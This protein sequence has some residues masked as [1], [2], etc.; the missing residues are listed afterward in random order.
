M[1]RAGR[2]LPPELTATL[3]EMTPQE[4]AYL[5]RALKDPHTAQ[6]ELIEADFER[7]PVSI[8]EF[9]SDP[10]LLGNTGRIENWETDEDESAGIYSFWRHELSDL[11][12]LNNAY[13]QW[14][15]QAGIGSGKSFVSIV[16]ILYKLYVLLCMR[17]PQEFCGLNR[18]SA[19]TAGFFSSTRDIGRATEYSMLTSIMSDSPFFRKAAGLTDLHRPF[20][21]LR[22]PKNI[23]IAFGS[24]A[25]HALGQNLMLGLMDEASFG[26]LTQDRQ[27]SELFNSFWRRLS[28]R[29]ANSTSPG[30]LIVASSKSAELDFV[31]KH[32]QKWCTPENEGL[33]KVTK[34]AVYDVV[35]HR[36]P[37][38][39]K[40]R[41]MVG[42]ETTPSR[43]LE[44]GELP[45][46][47]FEVISI[48]DHPALR[49]QY[50][51]DLEGSLRDL[52]SILVANASPLI[53]LREK[54]ISC[55]DPDR[56]HPFKVETVYAGTR[57]QLEI[58][59][60]LLPELLTIRRVAGLRPR[61]N[62]GMSRYMHV[63]IGL[64]H[65]ALG[66]A[67][68]HL[69]GMESRETVNELGEAVDE[70][71]PRLY[72][73]LLLQV[74]CKPGDQVDLMK[75][76]RF[77]RYLAQFCGYPIGG[78]SFDAFQS[79]QPSQILAKLGFEVSYVS[80]D[81]TET[82]YLTLASAIQNETVSYYE[83]PILQKELREL[84][85]DIQKR[86]VDHPRVNGDGSVGSKD[87]SDALCG[88]VTTALKHPQ[89]FR[90]PDLQPLTTRDYIAAGKGGRDPDDIS[91]VAGMKNV[92]VQTNQPFRRVRDMF[93]RQ[94][95]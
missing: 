51:A 25:Q 82:P 11:F 5:A 36:F 30:L 73:D 72:V 52:S 31:E 54:I 53:P 70:E 78:I 85:R 87:V 41:V 18:N 26:I 88:A 60:L 20:E 91:W 16:A 23:Q 3:A 9:L 61:V 67:M 64:K 19:I 66:L 4:R 43:L 63:D 42:N 58:Q 86:K 44:K 55:I 75:I 6:R 2:D 39:D 22:L 79:A 50:A 17:N 59:H 90:L 24:R 56:R 10:E 77:I 33:I 1:K 21:I 94:V 15:I 95:K 12:D 80:V 40:F 34:A 84:R 76:V 28:S 69:C 65:D 8:R 32:I 13:Q 71:I 68:C 81:R 89:S 29:F 27:M 47:G 38:K 49:G 83:Y 92:R 14:V 35:P 57:D 62:P 93:G 74:R 46:P 45:S 37:A 7:Q 48:P